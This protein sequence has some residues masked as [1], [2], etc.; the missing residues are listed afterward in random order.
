MLAPF[1]NGCDHAA[2]LQVKDERDGVQKAA[3]EGNT[4]QRPALMRTYPTRVSAALPHAQGHS[5]LA[6]RR[7]RGRAKSL[8]LPLPARTF[9]ERRLRYAGLRIPQNVGPPEIVHVCSTSNPNFR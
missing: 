1:N 2:M 9:L 4:L 5:S 6:V 7:L 8:F 3:L